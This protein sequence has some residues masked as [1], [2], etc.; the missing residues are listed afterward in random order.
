M[1]ILASAQVVVMRHGEAKELS[2]GRVLECVSPS[3]PKDW[4]EHYGAPISGDVVTLF[5]CVDNDWGTDWSRNK[6]IFYTPGT[7]PEAPDWDGEKSECGGGL[8][9]SPHPK[10]ARA[11]RRA[12]K[13]VACPVHVDDIVVHPDGDYPEKVKFKKVCAPV[14][15]VDENGERVGGE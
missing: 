1:K 11:F 3:A 4:A 5:K 7:Q 9:G 8:H 14:Y 13:Y 12:N 2:G 15:E 10:M 6:E